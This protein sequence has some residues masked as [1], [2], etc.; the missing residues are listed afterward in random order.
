MAGADVRPVMATRGRAELLDVV[1]VLLLV[2]AAILLANTIEAFVF[3]LAFSGGLTPTIVMTAASAFAVLGSRARLSTDAGR[4]RRALVIVEGVII[5][6]LAIDTALALFLT[7]HAVPL[8]AVLTRFALPVAVLAL[9]A[10]DAQPAA[11]SEAAP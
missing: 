5:A 7:H 9:L 1:R 11:W 3:G 4:G 8:V 2:Q 10:H 6:S